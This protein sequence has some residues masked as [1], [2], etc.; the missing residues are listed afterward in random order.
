[1]SWRAIRW[2]YERAKKSKMAQIRPAPFFPEIGRKMG[3]STAPTPLCSGGFHKRPPLLELPVFFTFRCEG[4]KLKLSGIYS[5]QPGN[6]HELTQ[7]DGSWRLV[8]ACHELARI[9]VGFGG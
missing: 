3:F 7:I 1:L 2:F 9:L 4:Y 5:N 6:I 8:V